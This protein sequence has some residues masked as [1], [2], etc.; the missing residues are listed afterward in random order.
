[1]N[2]KFVS[3]ASRSVILSFLGL[4]LFATPAFCQIYTYTD[5]YDNGDSVVGYSS[6]TGYYN[7]STH[8]YTSSITITSP[9]GRTAS[10]ST[11]GT[12]VSA[13]ISL[14]QEDGAYSFISTF[15]GT[16]PSQYGGGSHVVGAGGGQ[17]QVAPWVSINAIYLNNEDV[18]NASRSLPNNATN[19]P[20]DVH[21]NA[22]LSVQGNVTI[23]MI[24][25]TGSTPKPFFTLTGSPKTKYVTGGGSYEVFTFNLTNNSGNN[26]MQW[27]KFDASFVTVPSSPPSIQTKNNPKTTNQIFF[28]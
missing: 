10:S 7:S 4:I 14:A 26:G 3:C 6:V 15:V 18:V 5:G 21:V 24:E 19:V 2:R 12:S 28:Q 20:L 23:A 8:V 9:T 1:M 25:N 16:C 17:V 13:S 27:I 22:S 11:S